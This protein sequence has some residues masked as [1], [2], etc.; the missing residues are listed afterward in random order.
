MKDPPSSW[1]ELSKE[2]LIFIHSLN[3]AE[4]PS[5][6]YRM[7]VFLELCGLEL[8]GLSYYKGESLIE[9]TSL[10]SLGKKLEWI[11]S[12][13]SNKVPITIVLKKKYDNEGKEPLMSISSKSLFEAIGYYTKFLDKPYSLIDCK[14]DKIRIG[15]HTYAGPDPMMLGLTYEQYQNAQSAINSINYVQYESQ[16][17]NAKMLEAIKNADKDVSD[18]TEEDAK[19]IIGDS[20]IE[21]L[22]RIEQDLKEA[23]GDFLSAVLCLMEIKCMDVEQYDD[24]GELLIDEK[25]VPIVKKNTFWQSRKYSSEEMQR[26][27]TELSNDAPSWLFPLLYQWFQSSLLAISKKFPKLFKGNNVVEEDDPVKSFAQTLNTIMKEQGFTS[28]K[29]VLNTEAVL[30]FETLNRL[31]VQAEELE[32]ISKKK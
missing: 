11:E 9:E 16:S 5:V 27:K 13:L 19:R 25:G 14:I 18:F 29:D 6:I 15:Q 12:V 32:R 2:Q 24:K 10:E 23:Q 8:C 4:M 7:K 31:A 20:S 3:R 17:I 1:G 28:Q 22:K 30:N 21:E 26:V